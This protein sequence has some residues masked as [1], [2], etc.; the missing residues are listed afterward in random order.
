MERKPRPKGVFRKD[1]MTIAD[2]QGSIRQDNEIDGA[3]REQIVKFMSYLAIDDLKPKTVIS[4]GPT[5][6]KLAKLC[7]RRG[8]LYLQR[9][10]I[11]E[12]ILT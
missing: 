11:Q 7:P 6:R 4:Y 5:L 2:A 3:T 12:M 9:S 1:T 8:F 10:D